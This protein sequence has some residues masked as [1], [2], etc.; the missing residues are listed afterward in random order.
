MKLAAWLAVA[1]SSL[2][3]A[4]C[5]GGDDDNDD[6]AAPQRQTGEVVSSQGVNGGDCASLFN[7]KLHQTTISYA[8]LITPPFTPPG[9]GAAVSVP[10]CRV[11]G[12]SNP[13]SDSVINFEVW[14]PPAA[15]WN[16]K[17]YSGTGGGSTGAIQFGALRTGIAANY[18]AMSQ[19]RGHISRSDLGVPASTDGSWAAGHPEKVVDWAHRS[20]HVTTVASKAIVQAFYTQAPQHA[21][22]VGCS[23]GGH[24][25]A[26]EA[27]RYPGDYD[28][29]I[30]GAPAWNWSNLMAGRLWASHPSL[31][32]PADA[33]TAPKLA[34]L[35][36]AAIASCDAVDGLTDGIVDDPRKCSFDPAVLQCTGADAP[37]CL[38]PGQVNTARH[39]YAGP[40]RANGQQVFPGYPVS[41]ERLW[42]VNTGPTPGGS[43]FDYF[44]YWVYENQNYDSRTFN[45]DSDLDFAN[46]KPVAGDTMASVVNA[47]PDIRAFGDRG[48]KLLMW[49][50]WADEQVHALSSVDYHDQVVA[51]N[52]KAQADRFYRLFMLPG[53]AHCGGGVG[54]DSIDALGALERWVE[55]NVPP[56]RIIASKVTGGTVT[57]TRP[58]CPYPQVA[59]YNG[60]G[61]IDDAASF[62]CSTP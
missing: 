17:F 58:L 18:A 3:I 61:S 7:L 49:H 60:S 38:T 6:D 42:T 48:G 55:Q 10:F 43:S 4:G 39:I 32:N 29:I 26:M 56:D 51:A 20:Q 57:R 37:T 31:K 44:R 13:T 22:F 12:V 28:G 15:T 50:G 19:D 8:A 45:F 35:N 34:V 25:S 46:N 36:D 1:V 52:T 27:Y 40:K 16:R 2:L 47:R 14:L 62:T 5:G 53:V 59:R 23:A 21:Y 33:L 9:G 24:I 54:P 30:A 11:I 41:S